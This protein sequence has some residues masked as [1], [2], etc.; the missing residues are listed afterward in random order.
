MKTFLGSVLLLWLSLQLMPRVSAAPQ[1][2]QPEQKNK[3]AGL[4]WAYGFETPAPAAAAPAAG[5]GART[6]IGS[7]DGQGLPN[8]AEL[9][10]LIA[11]KDELNRMYQ[12]VATTRTSDPLLPEQ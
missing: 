11:L 8:A 1:Q 2:Q 7:A 3:Y 6:N 10:E 5:A 12:Q 9:R 4:P